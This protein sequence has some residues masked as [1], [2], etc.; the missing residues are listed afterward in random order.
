[1]LFKLGNARPFLL[2]STVQ[3]DNLSFVVNLTNPDI[4]RSGHLLL[5]RG[6]LHITRSKL[7]RQSTCFET[8]RFI[9]YGL[10]PVEVRFSIQ[11]GADFADIF[12]VR[13]MARQAR[14]SFREEQNGGEQIAFAYRG[15]DSVT[16]RT[17]VRCDPVPDS[18]TVAGAGFVQ[19]LGPKQEKEFALTYSCE[20]EGG[21]SGFHRLELR[22]FSRG[23]GA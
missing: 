2:N 17:I 14:G 3:E 13:G 5:P 8:F 4:Y 1:L 11:F 10:S 12:E 6:S 7:L 18:L 9:N 20:I 15:L 21:N 19:T 23:I 16:R 22:P